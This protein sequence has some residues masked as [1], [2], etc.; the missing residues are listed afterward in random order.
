M[1]SAVQLSGPL[2]HSTVRW[3]LV[4]TVRISWARTSIAGYF[5]PVRR[6]PRVQ[7]VH[8][9]LL[10]LNVSPIQSDSCL[11]VLSP[12][13]SPYGSSR[14]I[15]SSATFS[16]CL[17]APRGPRKRQPIG[18]LRQRPP[19]MENKGDLSSRC[20]ARRQTTSVEVRINVHPLS[21]P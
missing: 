1:G 10:R 16:E 5:G 15:P 8:S 21:L 17:K 3:Y 11:G 18:R 7:C 12:S 6:K 9:M 4:L 2:Y 14:S 20:F 13:R 19:Y